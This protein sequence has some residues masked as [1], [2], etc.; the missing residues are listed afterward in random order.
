MLLTALIVV[1]PVRFSLLKVLTRV[2]SFFC[3]KSRLMPLA[4]RVAKPE[5]LNSKPFSWMACVFSSKV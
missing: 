3:S 4:V 1:L 5:A 2:S